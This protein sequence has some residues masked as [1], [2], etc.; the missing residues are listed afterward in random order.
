F[1]LL[2][3]G[4]NIIPCD[5]IGIKDVDH[6][7]Q[8]HHNKL[9]NNLLAQS[10]SLMQG[11]QTEDPMRSFDGNRPS[12]TIILDKMDA[13][14]LGMLIA[15]YEHKIF[16]QSVIWNINAFDQFGVELG[17]EMAL[18]MENQDLED[19]DPSTKSLYSYLKS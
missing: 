19:A 8:D 6:P 18:K 7:Y 1:Q 3:Q 12:T 15:L 2:H 13:Y 16:V 9:L 14:H 4:T 10:Q 17:K 5:F 11:K